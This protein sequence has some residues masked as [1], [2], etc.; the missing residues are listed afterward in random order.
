MAKKLFSGKAKITEVVFQ[1][2]RFTDGLTEEQIESAMDI[3]FTVH[4]VDEEQA[5]EFGDLQV[6]LPL[7]ERPGYGK[8]ADKTEFQLSMETMK[9]NEI[10]S[11][12]DPTEAYGSV[13]KE[14]EVYQYETKP[15][16]DG[17]TY[18]RTKFGKQ[19]AKLS[20]E[21]VAA[22]FKKLTGTSAAPKEN[23]FE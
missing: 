22:R 13:G 18:V 6:E 5:K 4:P 2:P 8:Q 17:K 21:A 1:E 9:R 23:P 11:G 14:V 16:K 12:E 15:G 19:V 7:S 10:V 3:A 20:K